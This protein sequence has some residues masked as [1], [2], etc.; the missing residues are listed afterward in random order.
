MHNWNT[1]QLPQTST[2]KQSI[3]PQQHIDLELNH[4]YMG[5]F[6][7]F[8]GTLKISQ[9]FWCSCVGGDILVC[10]LGLKLSK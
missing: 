10:R 9:F 2:A 4:S 6:W 1:R 5:S 7:N 8:P 3:Q